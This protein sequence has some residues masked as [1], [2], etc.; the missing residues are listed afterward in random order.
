MKKKR[1]IMHNTAITTYTAPSILAEEYDRQVKEFGFKDKQEALTYL[2][3]GLYNERNGIKNSC[4]VRGILNRVSVERSPVL[5]IF[6]RAY[7]SIQMIGEYKDKILSLSDFGYLSNLMNAVME[8]FL[9]AG[10]TEKRRLRKEI[11][12]GLVRDI[13]GSGWVQ[14]YISESLYDRLFD[15][16]IRG[17]MSFTDMVRSTI[18]IILAAED[19]I[20]DSYPIPYEIQEAIEDNLRIEGF[21]THRF[22]RE[23]QFRMYV[24]NS[25]LHDGICSLIRRYQIPGPNEFLRRVLLFLVNSKNVNFRYVPD[26][27]ESKDSDYFDDN[28]LYYN[29][30]LSR[31]D[32]VRSIYQ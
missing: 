32:F 19:L 2:A 7:R 29:E 8:A 1:F 6:P 12:A 3:V 13:S 30:R 16:A 31:K 21:T 25:E 20:Q 10:K 9:A 14:T 24:G 5:Q 4:I 26:E 23:V 15:M 18:R 27:S 22:S 17:G 28:E 11:H